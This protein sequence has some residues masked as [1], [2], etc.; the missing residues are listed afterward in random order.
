MAYRKNAVAALAALLT[1]VIASFPAIPG[2][3][4]EIDPVFREIYQGSVHGRKD[5]LFLTQEEARRIEKRAREELTSRLISYYRI[6]DDLDELEGF[7][8]VQTRTIRTK[9]AT[10]L[11]ALDARG[12]VQNVRILGWAEPPEYRPGKRWLAQFDGQHRPEK[13]RL[14]GPIDAMSGASYTNRSVTAAV[15]WALAVTRVKLVEDR[16]RE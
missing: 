4:P 1:S 13:A 15:R 12:Y 10:I 9:P 3:A 14:R 8:F 7:A 16:E 5:N 2:E 6:H 11:V